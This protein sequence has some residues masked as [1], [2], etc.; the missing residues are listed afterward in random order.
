MA[1]A[2]SGTKPLRYLTGLSQDCLDL[3][4]VSLIVDDGSL[5]VHSHLL[6]VHSKVS[7][8]APDSLRRGLCGN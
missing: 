7:L 2:D 8:Q 1:D 3:A 5:P 4:D 6:T